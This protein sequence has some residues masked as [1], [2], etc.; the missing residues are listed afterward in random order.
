MGFRI[1][2]LGSKPG[3]ISLL[4]FANDVGLGVLR[5]PNWFGVLSGY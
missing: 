3:V 5:C 1:L 2:D 4:G